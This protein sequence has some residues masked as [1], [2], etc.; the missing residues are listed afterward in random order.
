M[1]SPFPLQPDAV[2]WNF[3]VACEQAR[4]LLRV[5]RRLRLEASELQSIG[6]LEAEDMRTEGL[7]LDSAKKLW[8]SNVFERALDSSGRGMHQHGR[9]IQALFDA[10]ADEQSPERFLI[11]IE[12]AHVDPKL[13]AEL[14]SRPQPTEHVTLHAPTLATRRRITERHARRVLKRQRE[15]ESMGDLFGGVM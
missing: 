8:R 11:A 12:I 2:A 4:Y 3:I 13:A 15:R 6:W 1:T 5:A 10:H 14:A 7:I 9:D